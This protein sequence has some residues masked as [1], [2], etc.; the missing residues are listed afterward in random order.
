M[1]FAAFDQKTLAPRI[2][3]LSGVGLLF[4]FEEGEQVCVDLIFQRR[5]H[6]GRC[7]ADYLRRCALYELG[8]G[9][10]RVG[11]GHNLIV[12]SLKD[13][14]RYVKLHPIFGEVRFEKGAKRP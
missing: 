6:A 5:A 12:I 14:R 13:A 10:R 2:R 4:L 7:S 8:R 1:D 3:L 11:D 9:H